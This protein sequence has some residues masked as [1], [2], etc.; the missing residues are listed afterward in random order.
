MF[1]ASFFRMSSIFFGL[2]NL[3]EKFLVGTH[4]KVRVLGLIFE[5][6]EWNREIVRNTT[7]EGDLNKKK[8]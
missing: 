6:I 1:I 4:Q 3:F 2:F 7:F 5:S 8:E